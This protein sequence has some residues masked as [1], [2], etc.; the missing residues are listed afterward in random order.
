MNF[1]TDEQYQKTFMRQTLGF[2]KNL[3]DSGVHL[4]KCWF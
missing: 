1:C 3:I 4:I 2:E